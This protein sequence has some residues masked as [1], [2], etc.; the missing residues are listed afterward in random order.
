MEND[1]GINRG[2]IRVGRRTSRMEYGL[3]LIGKRK[4]GSAD[5][6]G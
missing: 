1:E 5:L 4:K 6:W 3:L 2:D